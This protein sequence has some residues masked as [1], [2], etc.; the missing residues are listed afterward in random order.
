MAADLQEA[1]NERTRIDAE[2]EGQ[3]FCHILAR[4]TEQYGTAAA[5]SWRETGAQEWTTMTWAQYRDRVAEVTLGLKALGLAKGDFVAIMARNRP[6]HVLADW[7]IMHPAPHRS[8]STTRWPPSRSRTSPA[9]AR[10]GCLWSRIAPSWSGGRRSRPLPN[11]E[12]VIMIN[13]AEDFADYDWVTS[14]DEVVAK[15]KEA[16]AGPGGREEFERSWTQ[17]TPQDIITLI[18]TPGTT[19]PPRA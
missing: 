15:G 2:I 3:T 14:W 9:T 18:Y 12:R 4:N 11:L 1:Q 19:G 6:E 5:L 17:V 16:L 7:G 13:D 10:R 8:R